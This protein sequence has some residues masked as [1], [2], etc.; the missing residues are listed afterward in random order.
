MRGERGQNSKFKNQ[1]P[2]GGALTGELDAHR[3]TCQPKTC[4]SS[5]LLYYMCDNLQTLVNS[6]VDIRS[7]QIIMGTFLDKRE[8]FGKWE[9]WILEKSRRTLAGAC[10]LVDIVRNDPNMSADTNSSVQIQLDE[11][12]F[13][14]INLV[15]FA[16]NNRD[17]LN[18]RSE[19]VSLMLTQGH[20]RYLEFYQ[21]ASRQVPPNTP[22]ARWPYSVQE[23]LVLSQHRSNG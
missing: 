12:I 2:K 10:K 20:D 16:F 19:W 13:N 9:H 15:A 1:K 14:A 8:P 5:L 22:I 17:C 7:P 6:Q 11:V 23:A 3:C 4:S 21:H 18:R